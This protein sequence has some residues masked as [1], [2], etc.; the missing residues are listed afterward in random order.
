PS[1]VEQREAAGRHGTTRSSIPPMWRSQHYM[2]T[3][4]AEPTRQ[5]GDA[6]PS[7]INLPERDIKRAKD[8]RDVSQHM[9]ATQ[10]IHGRQMC[11]TRRPDLATVWLVGAITNQIDAKLPLGRF[12]AG[13]NLASGNLVAFGIEFEVMDHRFHRPLHF[14]ALGRHDLAIK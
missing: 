12:Y 10:E 13:V 4:P 8:R 2:R 9:A 3:M 1:T 5:P 11:K 14:G 6:Q 7:A